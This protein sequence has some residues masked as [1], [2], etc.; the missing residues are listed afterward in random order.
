MSDAD[1]DAR[2]AQLRS[3][4]S[5]YLKGPSGQTRTTGV[6]APSFHVAA[7]FAHSTRSHI[8]Q[9]GRLVMYEMSKDLE[10][11]MAVATGAPEVSQ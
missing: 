6:R 4:M 1:Q 10:A 8:E 11:I 5:I 3:Y 2:D 7:S 9:R